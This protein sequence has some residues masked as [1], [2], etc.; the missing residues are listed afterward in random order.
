MNDIDVGGIKYR[1]GF[2][3]KIPFTLYWIVW[4]KG[5]SIFE[6]VEK[7][8]DNDGYFYNRIGRDFR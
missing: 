6:I 2:S 8:F 3:I 7:Y 1:V 4:L 5:I